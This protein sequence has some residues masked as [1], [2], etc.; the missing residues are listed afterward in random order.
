MADKAWWVY[1][2]IDNFGTVDPQGPFWKPDSNIQLPPNYPIVAPTAGVVT[3]VQITPW[4]QSVV[5]VKFDTPINSLATHYFFEH[6]SSAVV[7]KGQKLSVGDLVGYNNLLPPPLG[8]GFYSGDQFGS[9]PEWNV[10]QAD[11]APHGPNQLNPVAYLDALASGTQL[12]LTTNASQSSNPV[13]GLLAGA[14]ITVLV[15][16]AALLLALGLIGFFIYKELQ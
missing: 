13:S 3:D 8:F 5:T 6:M 16:A 2:R 10:L 9:G 14:S 4:G 7:T 11:L 1:P 15:G 12:P